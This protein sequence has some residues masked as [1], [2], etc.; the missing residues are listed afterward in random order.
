MAEGLAAVG[1]AASILQ[2]IQIG[3][4]IAHRINIYSSKCGDLP[5]I[6]KHV[7]N[8]IGI[9]NGTLE[10]FRKAID[11]NALDEHPQKHILKALTACENEA[12]SLEALILTALPSV[13]DGNFKRAWKAVESVTYDEKVE[14]KM[15][16][17]ESYINILHVDI[18]V[19]S[20][21]EAKQ[22]E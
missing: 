9:I 19:S 16:N 11:P 7:H 3:C 13:S 4:Q 2:I 17:I 21:T 1:V 18:S 12:Q 15:S 22:C 6:F 20:I 14:K 10:N 8:K 5:D